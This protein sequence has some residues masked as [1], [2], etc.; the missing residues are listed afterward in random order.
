MDYGTSEE[1]LVLVGG[2]VSGLTLVLFVMGSVD[3]EEASFVVQAKEGPP[4]NARALFWWGCLSARFTN[5][6][7]DN[8]QARFRRTEEICPSSSGNGVSF[9]MPATAD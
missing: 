5:V 7:Q 9:G 1:L 6:Q 8:Q 3:K 2:S 4:P